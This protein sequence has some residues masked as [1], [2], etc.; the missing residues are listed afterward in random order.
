MDA[1]LL[2]PASRAVCPCC[3]PVC[4]HLCC[5]AAAATQALVGS[6]GAEAPPLDGSKGPGSNGGTT[7]ERTRGRSF[8]RAAEMP[9]LA[10]GG[11]VRGRSAGEWPGGAAAPH[12]AAQEA[13]E[14][15]LA[16]QSVLSELTAR[17]PSDSVSSCQGCLAQLSQLPRLPACCWHL[18]ACARALW[19]GLVS[20]PQSAARGEGIEHELS[21]GGL[22]MLPYFPAAGAA[23]RPGS[24]RPAGARRGLRPESA[25]AHLLRGKEL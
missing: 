25:L 23:P 21:M 15:A 3:A 10:G 14:V 20:W 4:C 17:F 7:E 1:A 16:L 5:Q 19:R 9:S 2:A 24:A 13:E 18:V 6:T 11:C 8:T 22:V 12:W